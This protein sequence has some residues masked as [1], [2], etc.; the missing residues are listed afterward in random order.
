ME[1]LGL[2]DIDTRLTGDKRLVAVEGR[3]PDG[4]T[5]KGYEMHIGETTGPDTTRPFGAIG[6]RPEGAVS[7]DGA[8]SGTYV[9]GLFADDCQRRAWLERLGGEASDLNYEAGV[10][11]TLD[12]LAEHLEA[13]L[14]VD[15]LLRIAR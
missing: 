6:G 5:F 2:L 12:A 11:A 3:T 9:H 4:V 14:D 8:V 15:A 13:H 7:A 1:G 10:D